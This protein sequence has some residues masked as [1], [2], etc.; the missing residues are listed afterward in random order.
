[1]KKFVVLYRSSVSAQG[2]MANATPE[3]AKEG[4]D[5]WMSWADENK[6]SIV[7]LGTPLSGKKEVKQKNISN[8]KDGTITGYSILQGESADS[9]AEALKEHPHFLSPGDSSIEVFE[10]LP[11]PGMK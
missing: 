9:I 11:M 7:D 8:L 4:M 5:A 10:I 2:Q 6:K 1:M 3:Q